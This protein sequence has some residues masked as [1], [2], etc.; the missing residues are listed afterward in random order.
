MRKSYT[1]KTKQEIDL[2]IQK[3]YSALI[4]PKPDA[5]IIKI[6]LTKTTDK[7]IEGFNFRL[8]KTLNKIRVKYIQ[9]VLDYIYVVEVPEEVSNPYSRLSIGKCALH[10]HIVL[11]TSITENEILEEIERHFPETTTSYIYSIGKAKKNPDV[12]VENISKRADLGN[13]SNYLIKQKSLEN[14][15]YNY[16]LN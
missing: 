8:R 11:R 16:K 14:G 1:L 3:A 12:Y 2:D 6:D 4:Q 10:A 13:Y 7:T 9:N 5:V 15:S